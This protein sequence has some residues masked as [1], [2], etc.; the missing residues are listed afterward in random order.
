MAILFDVKITLLGVAAAGWHFWGPLD[1]KFSKKSDTVN[2]TLNATLNDPPKQK[3]VLEAFGSVAEAIWPRNGRAS[4]WLP[5]RF[6]NASGTLPKRFQN[7]SGT[8]PKHFVA[9][10]KRCVSLLV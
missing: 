6:H 4:N 2:A 9:F 5:Q 3:S 7:A 8:L 10:W 1:I